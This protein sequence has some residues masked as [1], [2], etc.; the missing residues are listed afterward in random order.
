MKRPAASTRNEGGKS[1]KHWHPRNDNL[2]PNAAANLASRQA[3]YQRGKA[4]QRGKAGIQ[5][6]PATP[7]TKPKPATPIK[8]SKLAAATP[9]APA[10][11]SRAAAIKKPKKEPS[12]GRSTAARAEKPEAEK[13]EAKK[14]EK[15]AAE[16]PQAKAA[17]QK[18]NKQKP[19]FY[20]QRAPPATV[21]KATQLTIQKT[22]LGSRQ[23]RLQAILEVSDD[24]V[25]PLA[26]LADA[27]RIVD[28]PVVDAEG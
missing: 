4:T 13:P 18:T 22:K 9:K 19:Q 16:K 20:R 5:T 26:R 25:A 11:G 12:K 7:D 27:P 3:A 17:A 15:P 21:T 24:D 1:Q 10:K 8:P 2:A 23:S 14:P 28:E 6:A